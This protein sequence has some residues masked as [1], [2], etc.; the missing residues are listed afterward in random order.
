MVKNW[1]LPVP[2]ATGRLRERGFNQALQLAR[3]LAPQKVQPRMLLRLHATL[4]QHTLARVQR[5]RNL[6]GAFSVDP[7]CHQ[8]LAGRRV[9]MVDDVMTTGATL[10]A[11]AVALRRAGVLHLTTLVVARTPSGN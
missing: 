6:D 8:A 9:V 4:P 7:L 11:A 3:Q 2:L 1:V 5:L 10:R